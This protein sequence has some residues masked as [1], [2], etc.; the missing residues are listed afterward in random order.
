MV[1]NNELLGAKQ[2]VELQPLDQMLVVREIVPQG[3]PQT[4]CELSAVRPRP[5][6]DVMDL[7]GKCGAV[8]VAG[9][10][11][12]KAWLNA[13]Q[14]PWMKLAVE[15]H[16]SSPGNKRRRLYCLKGRLQSLSFDFNVALN[17]YWLK[18]S[19]ST[20]EMYLFTLAKTSLFGVFYL[21]FFLQRYSM[22]AF[23][24]TERVG[25]PL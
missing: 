16:I 14:L 23:V 20:H 25:V 15:A 21:N 10:D 18:T 3:T 7:Q 5:L 13:A 1:V 19:N 6:P 11:A 2:S 22:A 17:Y 8:T 12:D 4:H 24:L 9:R